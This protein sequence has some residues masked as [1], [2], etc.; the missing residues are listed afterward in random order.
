MTFDCLLCGKVL[1][2]KHNLNLHTSKCIGVP[3]ALECKKCFSLFNNKA[4]KSNH[5]KK[6]YAVQPPLGH[7]LVVK[8][9]TNIFNNN[10]N[11]IGNITNNITNITNNI[12]NIYGKTGAKSKK[13]EEESD[14]DE[15]EE[16]DDDY[17]YTN[18]NKN[19]RI[20]NFGNETYCYI[21]EEQLNKFALNLNVKGFIEQKH[22]NKDHPENHNIKRSNSKY[23]KILKDNKWKLE[24]KNE[25]M[26]QIFNNSRSQLYAY[27]LDN[28]F[29]KQLSDTQTDD[30]IDRWIAYDKIARKRTEE[31]IDMKLFEMFKDKDKEKTITL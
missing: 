26:G 11:N 24:T 4:T 13:R 20:N 18:E 17:K 3:S 12:T 1:S 23:Y 10:I 21:P 14:E 29:Y 7:Y 16:E 6:C 9:E 8:N 31:Y 22:F 25:I 30:Y 15:E 2:T 28:I 27:S 5:L 19:M